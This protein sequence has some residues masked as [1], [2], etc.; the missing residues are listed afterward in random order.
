MTYS[1]MARAPETVERRP[2]PGV[3]CRQLPGPGRRFREADVMPAGVGEPIVL[4]S[5]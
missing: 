3:G 1:I 4:G 5:L 2:V